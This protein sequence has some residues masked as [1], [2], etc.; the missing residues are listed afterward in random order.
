MG[1]EDL[2]GPYDTHDLYGAVQLDKN[3]NGMNMNEIVRHDN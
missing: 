3:D 2:L 1:D